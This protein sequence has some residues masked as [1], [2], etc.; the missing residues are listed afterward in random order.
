MKLFNITPC[1][2]HNEW[3]SFEDEVTVVDPAVEKTLEELKRIDMMKK[4]AS[5]LCKTLNNTHSTHIPGALMVLNFDPHTINAVTQMV[6][7]ANGLPTYTP[8][9]QYAHIVKQEAEKYL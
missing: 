5:K 2:V 6:R 9:P 7:V 3:L 1:F 8:H 4:E